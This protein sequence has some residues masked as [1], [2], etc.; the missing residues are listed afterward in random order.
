[1]NFDVHSPTVHALFVRDRPICAYLIFVDIP[2][3]TPIALAFLTP[4]TTVK[5]QRFGSL[6]KI[7]GRSLSLGR[8]SQVLF[9]LPD[10]R[11]P[12]LRGKSR[13][14]LGPNGFANAGFCR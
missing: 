4:G 6:V 5:K 2:Y 10:Q 11:L 12:S 3:I 7:S 8:S 1:M 9:L 14:P 13:P